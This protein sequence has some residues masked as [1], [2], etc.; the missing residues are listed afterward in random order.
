MKVDTKAD[1]YPQAS[2]LPKPTVEKFSS[3]I[4]LRRV[5]KGKE[6]VNRGER[7]RRKKSKSKADGL[8]RGQKH[9][10]IVKLL[11][12]FQLVHTFQRGREQR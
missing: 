3:S 1:K 9:R 4:P 11:L 10:V 12:C 5:E 8:H 2:Q 6:K 7:R